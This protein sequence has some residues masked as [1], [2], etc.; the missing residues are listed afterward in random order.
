MTLTLCIS[1][2][3]SNAF[4]PGPLGLYFFS[5]KP[6]GAQPVLRSSTLYGQGT[7]VIRLNKLDCIGSEGSLLQCLPNRQQTRVCDHSEDAGVRCGGKYNSILKGACDKGL[8][9]CHT[10][11]Y[12]ATQPCMSV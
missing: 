6:S 10:R 8:V 9:L 1:C 4:L 7:G 5:F 12:I 11:L 3:C 2:D